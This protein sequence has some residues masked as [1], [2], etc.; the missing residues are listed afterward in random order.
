GARLKQARESAGLTQEEV[1]TEVGISRSAV[2][3]IESGSRAVSSI[4]LHRFAYLYGRDMRDF[5]AADFASKNSLAGLFRKNDDLANDPS[6]VAALRR[7]LSMGRE[8]TQ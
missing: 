2:A 1:A 6:S 7:S 3:L 5:F 4:E 8:L